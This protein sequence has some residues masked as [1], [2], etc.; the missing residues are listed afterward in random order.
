MVFCDMPSAKCL[1]WPNTNS[2]D[3]MRIHPPLVLTTGSLVAEQ[4]Q[5]GG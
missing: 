2:A 5:P 4:P 3:E 1:L